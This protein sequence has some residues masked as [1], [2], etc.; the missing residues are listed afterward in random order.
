VV[1]AKGSGHV[2][3]AGGDS[4]LELRRHNGGDAGGNGLCG[5]CGCGQRS[6]AWWIVLRPQHRYQALRL[7]AHRCAALGLDSGTAAERLASIP[8]T[9]QWTA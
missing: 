9:P 1:G 7:K 8:S 3:Q 5:W 6:T 2:R 4:E